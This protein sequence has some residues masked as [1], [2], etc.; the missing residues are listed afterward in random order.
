MFNL[1][2]SF[3]TQRAVIM[4]CV[5]RMKLLSRIISKTPLE[6]NWQLWGEK[7]NTLQ[8]SQIK[9]FQILVSA[10]L[11][12]SGIVQRYALVFVCVSVC[13]CDSQKSGFLCLF[14]MASCRKQPG[15]LFLAPSLKW[16][17][18]VA[19]IVW[20][21]YWEGH[22]SPQRS[23]DVMSQRADFHKCDLFSCV[24]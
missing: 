12:L 14:F 1:S 8:M 10:R 21:P 2:I 24:F 17:S 20:T 23:S 11:H 13:V 4:S 16:S 15:S 5:W 3:Q 7:K 18:L 22:Q 6:C 9:H 19:V